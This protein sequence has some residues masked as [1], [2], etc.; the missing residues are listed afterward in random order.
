MKNVIIYL[1]CIFMGS[2][3]AAQQT[4]PLQWMLGV[5]KISTPQG[6]VIEIWEQKD[7]STLKGRSVF[8]KPN[9]DTLPQENIEMAF[10]NGEWYYIPTVAN[11][12]EG[13]PVSFKVI[14]LRA[15]EFVSENPAH[16]F[17]QRIVYRRIKQNMY[18]SIEGRKN[19]RYNK[20]NFDF[21]TE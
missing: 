13:K 8:V 2:Q 15:N 21:I 6:M 12:N 20:Q 17:P 4:K 9:K 5:W 11:Q 16:D 14:F 3:V 7:D 10:R 1:V 18:A 19:G